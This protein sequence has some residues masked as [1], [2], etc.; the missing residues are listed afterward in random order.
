[1]VEGMETL[2]TR[3]LCI[4]PPH[5]SCMSLSKNSFILMAASVIVIADSEVLVGDDLVEQHE[6][7]SLLLLQVLLVINVCLLCWEMCVW[8]CWK[9]AICMQ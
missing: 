8:Y 7:T 5:L 3:A 2:L 6:S 9:T 1:M 4:H